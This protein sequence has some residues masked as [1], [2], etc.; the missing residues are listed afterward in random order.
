[1]MSFFRGLRS[2]VSQDGI[3]YVI[4]L[5][6]P[7]L[8][9]LGTLPIP[10]PV[11]VSTILLARRIAKQFR[12]PNALDW[13]LPDWGTRYHRSVPS[14]LDLQYRKV[15][16]RLPQVLIHENKKG[17]SLNEYQISLALDPNQFQVP[18]NIRTVTEAPFTKI[19]AKLRSR[20][21]HYEETGLRLTGIVEAGTRA[22]LR[23]QPVRFEDYVR[24]NLLLDYPIAPFGSLRELVHP[25]GQLEPLSTSGLANLLGINILIFTADG[26][27]VL[28]KR[29][30]DVGVR[31]GEYAPSGSGGMSILDAEGRGETTIGPSIVIREVTEEIGILVDQSIS[32]TLTYMGVTR[33]LI[34]GGMPELFFAAK[35]NLSEAEVL[36]LSRG[37]RDRYEF[38]KVRTF[39]LG[40]F[41]TRRLETHSDLH[42]L[43]STLDELL[44]RIWSEASIPLLTAL[45]LWIRLRTRE[46]KN[47]Q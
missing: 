32:D 24:T 25:N 9:H 27:L 16:H 12:N 34:R 46:I 7:I 47:D 38:A 37:A 31:P 10:L 42:S 39:S 35:S 17:L 6:A 14:V 43:S 15:R 8:F 36:N 41:A 18:S 30:K 21:R 1:M 3:G 13:G 11:P 28:Q 4:G 23:V 19:I 20:P 45:A 44:D 29:S 22:I 26:R 5:A 33:E 40:V 2:T